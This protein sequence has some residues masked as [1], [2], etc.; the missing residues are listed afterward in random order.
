MPE[1]T[2]VLAMSPRL[3]RIVKGASIAAS[4]TL[5]AAHPSVVLLEQVVAE[6]DSQLHR[7]ERPTPVTNLDP[8]AVAQAMASAALT[9]AQEGTNP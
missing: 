4:E 6:L 1:P 7:G 9:A 5:P 8:K 2:I 3:A